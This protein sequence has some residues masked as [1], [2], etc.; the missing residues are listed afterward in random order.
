MH[1]A[2]L[3]AAAYGENFLRIPLAIPAM[4]LPAMATIITFVSLAIVC[5]AKQKTKHMSLINFFFYHLTSTQR[6]SCTFL[7]D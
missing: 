1:H 5:M 6:H 2:L 7:L 3:T 4:H